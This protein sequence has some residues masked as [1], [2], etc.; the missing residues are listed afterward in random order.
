MLTVTGSLMLVQ[1]LH[2]FIVEVF[3][4]SMKA[5]QMMEEG[6]EDTERKA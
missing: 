6:E 1:Q 4:C 3:C 2:S 5:C